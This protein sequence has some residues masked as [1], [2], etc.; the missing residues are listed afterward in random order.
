MTN[1]LPSSFFIDI[2]AAIYDFV[3]NMNFFIFQY[4]PL[5]NES[6]EVS[7]K[8]PFSQDQ[9][10]YNVPYLPGFFS[11]IISSILDVF[12][13]DPNFTFFELICSSFF[14]IIL[15]YAFIKYIKP[16]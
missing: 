9:I 12:G 10:S 16:N 2:P 14:I 7:Y 3:Y 1:I 8:N 13:L 4:R 5:L 6:L 15:V 11:T